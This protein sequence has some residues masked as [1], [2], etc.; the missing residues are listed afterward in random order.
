MAKIILLSL[1]FFSFSSNSTTLGDFAPQ[2]QEAF[3]NFSS[4]IMKDEISTFIA[5]G[6]SM[7]GTDVYGPLSASALIDMYEKNELATNKKL[8]GK[9]I[10]IKTISSEIGENFA[11][12][13]YIRANGKNQ[14]ENINLLVDGKDDRVLSLSAGD[15][16]DMVCSDVRYVMHTPILSKCIFSNDYAK[17]KWFPDETLIDSNF[18]ISTK[19]QAIAIL[20]YKSNEKKLEASCLKGRKDCVTVVKGIGKGFEPEEN[21]GHLLTTNKEKAKQLFGGFIK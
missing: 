2:S 18:N 4:L 10:R 19:E 11:R 7:T 13:A 8:K 12:E 20:L 14:F 9:P 21:F 6:K 15:K 3:K 17:S 16:V 1:L 5:G